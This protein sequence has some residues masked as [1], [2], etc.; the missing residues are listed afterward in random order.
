ME[1]LL[2]PG[3]QCVPF[4]SG[5]SA[6][7]SPMELL[8]TSPTGLQ[9]QK[10]WGLFLPIPDPQAWAPY[11]GLRTLTPVGESLIQL[12]SNLWAVQSVDMGLHISCNLPS[13]HLDVAS[14]LTSG[15]G[16][17]FESFQSMWLKFYDLIK[18]YWEFPVWFSRLRN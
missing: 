14:F 15:V 1:P 4:K 3:T 9:C 10:L 12:L 6:S 17:N 13:Y 8:H 16:Y 2:R 18:M 7:P 5:V 11:V